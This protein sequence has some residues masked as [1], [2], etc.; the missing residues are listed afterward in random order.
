MMWK[1]GFYENSHLPFCTC[2]K[3]A[4]YHDVTQC[5]GVDVSRHPCMCRHSLR[6]PIDSDFNFSMLYHP[7]PNKS[8]FEACI[9]ESKSVTLSPSVPPLTFFGLCANRGLLL[10]FDLFPRHC[11]TCGHLLRPVKVEKILGICL[12]LA[13]LMAW[14]SRKISRSVDIFVGF[15]HH[16]QLEDVSGEGFCLQ[17]ACHICNRCCEHSC[18]LVARAWCTCSSLWRASRKTHSGEVDGYTGERF[19]DVQPDR[20]GRCNQPERSEV[21]N[22][23]DIMIGN[24]M[25]VMTFQPILHHIIQS[26]WI[27]LNCWP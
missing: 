12:T 14:L 17:S 27:V 10:D 11:S 1:R 2:C 9:K 24:L 22:G 4:L 23:V 16:V 25:T 7:M 15:P 6:T 13:S 21:K 19:L 5:T 20:P 3:R 26:F 8:Y 18:S